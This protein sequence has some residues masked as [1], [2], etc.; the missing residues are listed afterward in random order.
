MANQDRLQV[1]KRV[2]EKVQAD[3]EQLTLLR[4]IQRESD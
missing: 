4:E 1:I 3:K 2:D